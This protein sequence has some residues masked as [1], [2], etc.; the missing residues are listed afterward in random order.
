MAAKRSADLQSTV[1]ALQMEVEERM[2][3]EAALHRLNA[4]LKTL[5]RHSMKALEADLRSVAKQLHDS[6][7]ASLAIIKF[8]LEALVSKYHNGENIEGPDLDKEIRHLAETIKESKEIA[9]QLRPMMLDDFGLIAT[10]GWL[11]RQF[12]QRYANLKIEPS[13]TAR[14][15][16]IDGMLKIICYRIV[17]E[18]MTNAAKHSNADRI[19]ILLWQNQHHLWLKI[20]DNG[21]G[22]DTESVLSGTDPLLGNG[23]MGMRER[24][25]I[26]GGRFSLT[27]GQGRGT[28]IEARFGLEH[29]P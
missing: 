12:K 6:I 22:F 7:G 21:Q 26:S 25:K 18:A 24:V 2:R 13:L 14:E 28:C 19:Q 17:H 16:D 11:C 9:T 4:E 1:K 5:S 27:S 20:M 15:K 3:A 8:N 29:G 23:L 10:I